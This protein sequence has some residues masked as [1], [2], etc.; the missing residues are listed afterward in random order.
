MKWITPAFWVAILLLR[1]LSAFTQQTWVKHADVEK[2]FTSSGSVFSFIKHMNAKNSTGSLSQYGYFNRTKHYD[3]YGKTIIQTSTDSNATR[4]IN[5]V[6][7]SPGRNNLGTNSHSAIYYQDTILG[8]EYNSVEKVDSVGKLYA[9]FTVLNTVTN[10]HDPVGL[11]RFS[12]KVSGF[13]YLGNQKTLIFGDFYEASDGVVTQVYNGMAVWDMVTNRLSYALGNNNFGGYGVH[14]SSQKDGTTLISYASY[15]RLSFIIEG[16]IDWNGSFLPSNPINGRMI[17]AH[18]VDKD[19][20]YAVWQKDSTGYPCTLLK[21]IRSQGLLWQTIGRFTSTSAST[22]TRRTWVN[23]IHEKN[24][25]LYIATEATH[26]N[27]QALGNNVCIITPH[28]GALSA[29]PLVPTAGTFFGSGRLDIVNNTVYFI[30]GIENA[31]N[32]IQELYVLRDTTARLAPVI[33]GPTTTQ[34]ASPVSIFGT[35]PEPGLFID[36]YKTNGTFLGTTQA[37]QGSWSVSI[38]LPEGVMSVR[39]K[40]RNTDGITSPYSNTLSVTVDTCAQTLTT[41]IS[42]INGQVVSSPVVL[43]GTT[44]EPLSKVAIRFKQEQESVISVVSPDNIW[45][46]TASR[47]SGFDTVTITPIDSVGHR[48]QSITRTFVVSTTT[49]VSSINNDT[50]VVRIY[51]NPSQGTFTMTQV[52]R[53][54]RIT[55]VSGT[56]IV[57][58]TATLNTNACTI[59]LG[60]VSPGLYVIEAIRIDGTQCIEK[61]IVVH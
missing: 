2:K 3:V 13:V 17:A 31:F 10:T 28:T 6:W 36:L 20:V 48:G 58:Y 7:V 33:T 61:L 9:A 12:A 44:T 49:S 22:S 19:T 29:L 1:S 39:A 53:I 24:G 15:S 4:K 55:S 34:T 8:K 38:P 25:A 42:L 50:R 11:L 37:V 57:R 47:P 14:S 59:T 27:S 23:S 30:E 60:T 16:F 40:A 35:V 43:S 56:P 18:V 5:G 41:T 26:Y 52:K 46:N 51:P 32:D 54:V 45:S 21:F